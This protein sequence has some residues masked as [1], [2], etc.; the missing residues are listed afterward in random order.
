MS[1][2][3]QSMSRKKTEKDRE[4]ERSHWVKKL[5]AKAKRLAWFREW[6]GSWIEPTNEI[7]DEM[8]NVSKRQRDRD[9]RNWK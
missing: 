1:R 7:V 5:I 3:A 9:R 6:L 4:N 8:T 2:Y